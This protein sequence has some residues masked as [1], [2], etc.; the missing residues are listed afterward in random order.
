MREILIKIILL[1]GVFHALVAIIILL[2]NSVS[3]FIKTK[4]HQFERFLLAEKEIKKTDVL[5]LGDS[6]SLCGIDSEELSELFYKK[7]N[8]KPK[9]LNL[10]IWAASPVVNEAVL[11]DLLN[12][13]NLCHIKIIIYNVTHRNLIDRGGD[14]INFKNSVKDYY[15]IGRNI[16]CNSVDRFFLT[17]FSIK[18]KVE[19]CGFYPVFNNYGD[20]GIDTIS[21]KQKEISEDELKNYYADLSKYK[22]VERFITLRKLLMSFPDST[23]KIVVVLPASKKYFITVMRYIEDSYRKFLANCKA[24]ENIPKTK[25]INLLEI[26]IPVKF[27]YNSDHVFI[28]GRKEYTKIL[29]ENL[30]N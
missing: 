27:Y 25:F 22:Q 28:T 15:K 17:I 21:T 13:Q 29:F 24:L 7:F 30:P 8:Y 2:N 18:E 12:K 26:E 1:C 23:Q 4:E 11:F 10:S 9:I 16:F 19:F 5:I 6:K 3:I 14:N 20:I